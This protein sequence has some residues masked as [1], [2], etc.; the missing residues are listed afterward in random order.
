MQ[1]SSSDAVTRQHAIQQFTRLRYTII[2]GSQEEHGICTATGRQSIAK[3]VLWSRLRAALRALNS[4]STDELIEAA[5]GVLMD[6]RSLVSLTHA[7]EQVYVLLKDGIKLDAHGQLVI[8][9]DAPDAEN[10]EDAVNANVHQESQGKKDTPREQDTHKTLQVINWREPEKND[11]ALVS[12]FWVGGTLGKRCLDLVGFVNG[13]P[14][15]LLEIA[16]SE[17]PNIF[18]RVDRD[19]KNTLP[20]LFWYNAFIVVADTFTCKMGS[21]TTPWE[22]FFQWKRVRDEREAENTRLDTLIEGTCHKERLLDIVENFTLFDR[23]QGL[24]KLVA[25]NHQC[26]GVNN[27]IASL[28]AWERERQA[29]R[30]AGLPQP[31]K[32]HGKLGVFW[33]TQ[34]SGKSYSMVFFV[35]KVQRTIANDYTFVVVT[36]RDELDKQI[37]EN[38][39]HT[40]T[41]SEDSDEIHARNAEHLKRLLG[42]RHLL[43]FTL[44]QKFRSDT[45]GHDYEVQSDS[46]KIIVMADEAHRTQYDIL[47]KNMRDALPRASFLGFTGTPLMDGEEQTR[48]TFGHY[49]SIYNFRRAINDGVTVPLYYENHTPQIEITNDNFATEMAEILDEAMLDERQEQRVL[50]QYACAENF[51]VKGKRLDQVASDIVRHFMNRGYMGKA[52]VVSINKVTAVRT[53]NRVQEQWR[54]YREELLAQL[55]QE[56]DPDIRADL[57]DKIAYMEKTDMAVVVSASQEDTERFARFSRETGEYIDIAPHHERFKTQK[58]AEDFKDAEHPLRIAFVC[59]MWMTGFDVRCLSTI[60]LDRLLKGHTLMQ[61]IARANRVFKDKNNGLIVDYAGAIYALTAALAVYAREDSSG[62]REGDRPI[63]DKSDLVQSLRDK[64]VEMEQFCQER[65]IDVP[66][67][68]AGLSAERIKQQQELIQAAIDK[69]VV[70]DEIKLNALLLTGEVNKFYKAILPDATEK[71]FALPVHFFQL[72]KNGIYETMRPT[73]ISAVLGRVTTLV[74]E[75]LEVYEPEE[76]LSADMRAP[77]GSFDLRDIDLDELDTSLHSGHRHIK[78]EQMRQ[79]LYE[80]IRRMIQVNPSRVKLLEKLQRMVDRYNEGCTNLVTDPQ[81]INPQEKITYYPA[82]AKQEQLLDAY[83][84][85]L[86]E[87]T[88]EVAQEEQRHQQEGFSEEELAIFDLLTLDVSLPEEERAQ[89]KQIARDVLAALRP[90]FNVPDWQKQAQIFNR[91]YVIIE[92]ELLNLPQD[93]YSKELFEQKRNTLLLYVREHYKNDGT[94]SVA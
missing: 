21:L 46:E 55:A 48:E 94:I 6:N 54:L 25:R 41:I 4:D 37:F 32:Q 38:F 27:A 52:M 39:R 70:T 59:G 64:L 72:I 84:D 31:P 45:P 91:A 58:L 8:A 75:S 35:R 3:V 86:V 23:G 87:L 49:V 29:G 7:N 73:G 68:L 85:A 24:N 14:F 2:D 74:R 16:D 53:Y 63:G 1:R 22:H 42:E 57:V 56:S 67:L 12:R 11:F 13:L 60:Y 88:G 34:G 77:R 17:L 78:A 51:V 69:L 61:T 50:E 43:L 20:A 40:G 93:A 92:D 81:L 28:Y 80:R 26:L 33:H 10:V 15:I 79:L 36:D 30:Q 19:Y 47:A 66:G 62:Y 44:I 82:G 18:D 83:D 76:R 65:G 9:D 90:T 5:I 89:V 71:E